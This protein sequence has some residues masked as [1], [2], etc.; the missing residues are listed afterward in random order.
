MLLLLTLL[1]MLMI[2]QVLYR[3]RSPVS[4]G[5]Y[6]VQVLSLSAD[7]VDASPYLV[8]QAL[9]NVLPKPQDTNASELIL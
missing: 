7:V 2:M 4:P 6:L 1:L 8:P 9:V 3:N 5:I